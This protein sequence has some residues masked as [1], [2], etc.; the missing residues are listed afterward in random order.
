[1]TYSNMK[2]TISNIK[3]KYFL[4][5]SCGNRFGLQ[6]TKV[7]EEREKDYVCITFYEDKKIIGRFYDYASLVL[8]DEEPINQTIN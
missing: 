6:A 2:K 1:M 8:I 4:T 7:V 3:R 5:D